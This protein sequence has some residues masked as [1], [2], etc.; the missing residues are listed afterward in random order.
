M[1]FF[2]HPVHTWLHKKMWFHMPGYSHGHIVILRPRQHVQ[3]V[4]EHAINYTYTLTDLSIWC[5]YELKPPQNVDE[6][7]LSLHECKAHANAVPGPPAKGHVHHLRTTGLLFSC[8]PDVDVESQHKREGLRNENLHYLSIAVYWSSI[9]FSLGYIH[10]RETYK[11]ILH[12]GK[13]KISYTG[14]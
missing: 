12:G 2:T 13:L 10:N 9:T 5:L 14:I 6:C 11:Y 4:D 8:E 3:Y 7:N 1:Q